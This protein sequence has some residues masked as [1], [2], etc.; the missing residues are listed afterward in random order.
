VVPFMADQPFWGSR[1][2]ELGVGT[3]PIPRQK[4]TADRLGDALRLVLS[5]T[6]MAGRADAIAKRIRDEDGPGRAVA[7]IAR[8]AADSHGHCREHQPVRGL[9]WQTPGRGLLS[10]PRAALP[11]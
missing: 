6:R 10:S 4:L 11:G 7:V 1:V 5:D 8:H 2:H 3:E 9:A